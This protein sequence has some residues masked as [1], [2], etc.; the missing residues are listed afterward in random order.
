MRG[1]GRRLERD[2]QQ[3]IARQRRGH[4]RRQVLRDDD[5]WFD[6]PNAGSGEPRELAGDSVGDVDHVGGS[7]RKQLIAES[8]ELIRDGARGGG[9]RADPVG[10]LGANPNRYGIE[11]LGVARDHRVGHEDL[12][13]VGV[14]GPRYLVRQSLRRHGDRFGGGDDPG[15]L[16]IGLDR[17]AAGSR[18]RAAL[19]GDP[20]TVGGAGSR[21]DSPYPNRALRRQ[22]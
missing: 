8:A 22:A 17:S 14:A 20:G 18:G 19:E 1:G 6:E 7:R 2:A 3:A 9:D 12:R 4:R 11:K 16:G 15:H 21:G 13:F 5:G 10:T